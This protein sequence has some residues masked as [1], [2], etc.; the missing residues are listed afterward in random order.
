MTL[1]EKIELARKRVRVAMRAK[2]RIAVLWS[3]GKDSMVVL[4]L[5]RETG[6]P[7]ELVH[8]RPVNGGVR[9]SFADWVLREWKLTP[10]SLPLRNRALTADDAGNVNVLHIYQYNDLPLALP[11]E[12]H[13]TYLPDADSLCL[14]DVFHAPTDDNVV[15]PRYD[16]LLNGTRADDTDALMQVRM[17]GV[18]DKET[19]FLHPIYEW[20]TADIWEASAL[21]GI[22]QNYDRYQNGNLLANSDYAPMCTR[23]VDVR[24]DAPQQV[25]CPKD[26]VMI[27]NFGPRLAPE[28][29]EVRSAL[30]L[31]WN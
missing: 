9:S 1:T 25:F 27:E 28:M 31:A 8:L 4:W 5:A 30:T 3:D 10:E 26:H 23:C 20:T 13:S 6:L 14:N 22:P 17:R 18:Y 7:F 12:P 24:P 11:V 29:K 19:K 16:I 2:K 21:L 15:A